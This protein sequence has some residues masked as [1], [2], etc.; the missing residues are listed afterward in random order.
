MTPPNY[1][2]LRHYDTHVTI[3]VKKVCVLSCNHYSECRHRELTV[4][5]VDIWILFVMSAILESDWNP[6]TTLICKFMGLK[7]IIRSFSCNLFHRAD[8]LDPNFFSQHLMCTRFQCDRTGAFW[9][10]RRKMTGVGKCYLH[11]SILSANA[12]SLSRKNVWSSLNYP[13]N[14][15]FLCAK[16]ILC[17]W[18]FENII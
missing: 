6:L 15:R 11:V 12:V 10:I 3:Y 4:K 17:K 7:W 2:K 13:I 1:R 9:D 8:I 14:T 16:L 5:T 18:Y